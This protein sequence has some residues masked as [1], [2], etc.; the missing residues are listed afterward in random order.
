M[1]EMAFTPVEIV[2]KAGQKVTWKNSSQVIHNVVDDAAKAVNK[3]DVSLPNSVRPFH[4][5]F[6]NRA[7]SSPVCSQFLE[8]TATFAHCM[9]GTARKLWSSSND[10]G[11]WAI[12]ATPGA[13]KDDVASEVFS[14]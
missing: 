6:C 4:S 5:E 14:C 8:F 13:D 9:R 11:N 10:P 3:S 2:I 1:T 7:R 12:L